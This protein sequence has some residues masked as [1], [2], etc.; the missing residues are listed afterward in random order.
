MRLRRA[1]ASLRGAGGPWRRSASSSGH[2]MAWK[3]TRQPG[4]RS[5]VVPKPWHDGGAGATLI[6][7][8]RL[9]P[10][11]VMERAW[12]LLPSLRDS[13]DLDPDSVD[14]QPTFEITTMKRGGGKGGHDTNDDGSAN[15]WE[16]VCMY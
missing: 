6:H 4:V 16:Y 2:T 12:Q 15:V 14:G 3:E 7:A 1:C 11:E 13:L 10:C 8:E 9:V 5:L